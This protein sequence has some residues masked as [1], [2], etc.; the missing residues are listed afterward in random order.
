[1]KKPTRQ[2]NVKAIRSGYLAALWAAREDNLTSESMAEEICNILNNIKELQASLIE[3]PFERLDFMSGAASAVADIL[4]NVVMPRVNI[5]L[6][7]DLEFSADIFVKSIAD[8]ANRSSRSA[9]G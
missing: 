2:K 8:K 1:M 4:R 3:D 9:T 6:D 7:D 5:A